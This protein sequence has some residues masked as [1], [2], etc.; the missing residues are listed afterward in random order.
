MSN[1]KQLICGNKVIRQPKCLGWAKI[2]NNQK[3]GLKCWRITPH[4][5]AFNPAFKRSRSES[6]LTWNKR[7]KQTQLY[8]EYQREKLN[9]LKGQYQT[10]SYLNEKTEANLMLHSRK[11][12]V[13]LTIYKINVK[14]AGFAVPHSSLTI[15]WV[16]L[17]LCWSLVG[18][19]FWSRK[20][21]WSW[22]I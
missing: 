19:K 10:I 12:K 20:K 16:G 3:N 21:N 22:K 2:L 1:L 17:W 11:C 14:Q 5:K 13:N 7:Q 9:S 4:Y 15:G 18:V 6:I 8:T